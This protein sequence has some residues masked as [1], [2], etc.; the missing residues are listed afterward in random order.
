MGLVMT[1]VLLDVVVLYA[2]VVVEVSVPHGNAMLAGLKR[3]VTSDVII[4]AKNVW[5][6]DIVMTIPNVT[7]SFIVMKVLRTYSAHVR[8]RVRLKATV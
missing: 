3:N 8:R 5:V 6:Q 1:V 7:V 4:H 2:H